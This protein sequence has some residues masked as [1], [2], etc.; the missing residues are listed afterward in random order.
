MGFNSEAFKALSSPSLNIKV[1]HF[2]VL[3][4]FVITLY[5]STYPE[6]DVNVARYNIFTEKKSIYLPKK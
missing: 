3:P 4:R 2:D 1:T 6:H 5:D